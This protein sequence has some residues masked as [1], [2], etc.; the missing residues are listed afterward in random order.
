M[1]KFELQV[2]DDQMRLIDQFPLDITTQPSGLGFTQ[3][4]DVIETKTIDYISSQQIKKADIKLIAHFYEPE[5]YAK[6]N[7][8]RAWYGKYAR[9]KMVLY[10]H[11]GV[12]ERWIDCVIKSIDVCEIETGINSVPITIQALSPF[13]EIKTKIIIAIIAQIGK[14]YPYGYPYAYGGGVI[15]NAEIN[16]TFYE[17]IPLRVRIKGKVVNPEISLKDESETIYTTV[18]IPSFTVEEGEFIDIDAIHSRIM[19]YE[20]EAAIGLDLYND[21]D[22][23][24]DTFIWAKPGLS[25]IVANLDQN[26]PMASIQISYVQYIL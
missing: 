1:R 17:E 21:I 23:S 6:V 14:E 12:K 4:I 25:R 7:F 11:D 24:K 15:E 9:S 22:K 2:Y 3:K 5:S 20:H 18:K 8:M 19:F 13:Y 26:E 16:N 10:Y